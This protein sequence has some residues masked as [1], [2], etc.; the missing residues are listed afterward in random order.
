MECQF[1]KFFMFEIYEFVKEHRCRKFHLFSFAVAHLLFCPSIEIFFALLLLLFELSTWKWNCIFMIFDVASSLKG[2][3]CGIPFVGFIHPNQLRSF[4]WHRLNRIVQKFMRLQF[5]YLFQLISFHLMNVTS[6]H[7]PNMEWRTNEWTNGG[8][9]V[10]IRFWKVSG[11][12]LWRVRLNSFVECAERMNAQRIE[13]MN[14]SKTK[15]QKT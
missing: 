3:S 4:C 7:I 14:I 15:N 9:N 8:K 11:P 12:K 6:Y 13:W 10:Q 5:R 2:I 1:C